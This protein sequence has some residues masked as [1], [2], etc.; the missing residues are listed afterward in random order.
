MDK[1][2]YFE[3]YESERAH[4]WFLARMKILEA[5]I[6]MAFPKSRELN[7]LNIG[8]ATG[9]SSEMLAKFGKVT[10][11]EYNQ[12]CIDF[13]KDKL[14]FEVLY[15]SI[16]ELQFQDNEFDLVCAFDVV[17]HVDDD[18][19][20]VKEMFRVC[21]PGGLVFVTVPAFSSLWG[22]H[23]VVNHHFRRYK[24][25]R[26]LD[27]GHLYGTN[28]YFS[29]FNFFLFPPIY[30][31]R[32][33]LNFLPKNS[34]RKDSGSDLGL[35]KSTLINRI[36]FQIFYAENI[37]LKRGYKLPFGVSAMALWHK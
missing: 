28:R 36:Y 1:E 24:K 15:G 23:D 17:E 3:Y 27:L 26:L 18:Y 4:W 5:Q 22:P 31:I 19:L 35:V 8:V 30:L 7:I 6:V 32:R 12:E 9:A 20:A 16:L 34:S 21:K 10:S 11:I 14:S 33:L 13:M 25:T 2:Y 29:Y 37:F